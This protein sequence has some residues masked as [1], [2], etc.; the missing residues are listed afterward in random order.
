M[1]MGLTEDQKGKG[2]PQTVVT[3]KLTC[4][5][6]GLI[7]LCFQVVSGH[8]FDNSRRKDS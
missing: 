8:F 1:E 3:L 5:L 2:K 7:I 4:C 6:K